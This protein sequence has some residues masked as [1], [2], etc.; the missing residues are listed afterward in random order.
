MPEEQHIPYEALG[1]Y[2]SGKID[3]DE[4]ASVERH[5]KDCPY[6]RQD[7]ADASSWKETLPA[8]KAWWKFW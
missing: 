6:C 3:S 5:L 7:I 4:K 8:E 2:L 1:R